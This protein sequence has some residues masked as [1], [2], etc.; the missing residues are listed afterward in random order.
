M[1]YLG[2]GMQG[3]LQPPST[4]ESVPPDGNL[5]LWMMQDGWAIPLMRESVPVVDSPFVVGELA[6]PWT[7]ELEPPDDFACLCRW[8]LDRVAIPQ[9][10]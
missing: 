3:E 8:M 4:K 10:R 6:I 5:G 7:S 1:A 9:R 2:Q